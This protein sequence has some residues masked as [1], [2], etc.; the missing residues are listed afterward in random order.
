MLWVGVKYIFHSPAL[1]Q[2][3]WKEKRDDTKPRVAEH[4]LMPSYAREE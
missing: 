3:Q 4:A 1:K 2:A